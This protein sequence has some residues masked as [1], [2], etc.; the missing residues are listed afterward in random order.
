MAAQ[1]N[2]HVP[3][4]LLAVLAAKAAAEGRTV[5]DLAKDALR[6]GLLGHSGAAA[7][8]QP[9]HDALRREFEEL[10]EQWRRETQHFSLI[11]KK[12]SHP[13]Y[14]R[15]MGMGEAVV[16]LLLEALRERPAHWFAAL[17][18]T[19]NVDP[20]PHGTNPAAAR[21]AW[22]RWGAGRGLVDWTP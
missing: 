8:G 7:E 19:A 10:A 17:R 18:A 13:A 15:I 16:P 22:L 3:E 12:V 11:S 4:D 20:V 6:A 5:D 9:H 21:E 1:N 14:F 2:L